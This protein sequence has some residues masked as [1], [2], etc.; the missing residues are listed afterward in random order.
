LENAR[1]EENMKDLTGIKFGRWTVIEFV[2]R[3]NKNY[4]WKCVCE[5]GTIKIIQNPKSLKSKSCGCLV[6]EINTKHGLD[7]NKLYHVFNSMKFRCYNEKCSSYKYYGGRGIIICDEWLQDVHNFISWSNSNGYENGLTIDRIDVNGNYCPENCRWITN[8]E[9]G[10]NKANNTW[11][12]FN[13]ECK[14][15]CQWA[16]ELGINRSTLCFRIYNKNFSVEE[17]FTKPIRK[18]GQTTISKESTNSIDTNLE[19]AN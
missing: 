9:Q 4:Y 16:D 3:K 10:L 8:K 1:K 5:C 13:G 17:A 14:T 6:K 19:A 2:E 7:G 15:L 12:T 18:Q 11:L